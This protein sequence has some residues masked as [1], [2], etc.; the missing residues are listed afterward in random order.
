MAEKFIHPQNSEKIEMAESILTKVLSKDYRLSFK[1]SQGSATL[2]GSLFILLG[3]QYNRQYRNSHLSVLTDITNWHR[4]ATPPVRHQ[5][6]GVDEAHILRESNEE[7]EKFRH[8][9]AHPE[10]SLIAHDPDTYAIIIEKTIALLLSRDLRYVDKHYLY[11]GNDRATQTPYF[12][13]HPD[14]DGRPHSTSHTS[15]YTSYFKKYVID[16]RPTGSY[17]FDAIF[18]DMRAYAQT[19][20]HYYIGQLATAWEARNPSK[21]F[22]S[23]D[24]LP[25]SQ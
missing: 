10:I 21:K 13:P 1:F 16:S 24:F 15:R 19:F 18:E 22:Y 6:R 7:S 14:I 20:P 11:V 5:D 12:I 23:S 17:A 8:Y 25:V 2:Q 4:L 3:A 9:V